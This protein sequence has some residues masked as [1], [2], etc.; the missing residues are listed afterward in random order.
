MAEPPPGAEDAA[1][2]INLGSISYSPVVRFSEDNQFI[3]F[4]V[5]SNVSRSISNVFGWVYRKPKATKEGEQPMALMN[6]PHQSAVLV[7]GGAHGPG[8]TEEWRFPLARKVSEDEK[9]EKY[10]LRVDA[11]SIFFASLEPQSGGDAKSGKTPAPE[12]K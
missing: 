9:K 10:V 6:N 12:S 5:R 11:R 2:W 1:K 4:K 3:I 8:K 7:R